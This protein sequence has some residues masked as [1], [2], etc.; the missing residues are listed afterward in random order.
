MMTQ[1]P[2]FNLGLAFMRENT[3]VRLIVDRIFSVH[4]PRW[5]KDM[6]SSLY[7]NCSSKE[8]RG[9]WLSLWQLAKWQVSK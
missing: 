1:S 8:I 5:I 2:R 4:H 3:D 9:K 7:V 6:D